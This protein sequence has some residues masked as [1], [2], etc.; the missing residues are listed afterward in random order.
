MEYDK[1]IPLVLWESVLFVCINA[2]M[3]KTMD[4]SIGKMEFVATVERSVSITLIRLYGAM[5][6]A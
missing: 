6:C 2:N 3:M 5:A 1:I 4:L